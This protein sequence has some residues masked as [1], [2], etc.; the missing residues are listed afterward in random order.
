MLP[1]ATASRQA[2]RSAPGL[3]LVLRITLTISAR[4]PET[5]SA[6]RWSVGNVLLAGRRSTGLG[7]VAAAVTFTPARWSASMNAVRANEAGLG[8]SPTRNVGPASA[9]IVPDTWNT[10]GFGWV[11]VRS[12]APPAFTV[13][14]AEVTR[15][16][17]V[18]GR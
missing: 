12:V 10:L 15:K 13:F 1:D 7:P 4:S 9:A 5:C 8:I 3:W 14:T 6:T 2:I 18:L 17:A 16:A 11:T